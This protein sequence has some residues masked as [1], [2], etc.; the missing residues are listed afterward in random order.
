MSE[1]E[2]SSISKDWDRTR[3]ILRK[4]SLLEACE[5]IQ[6]LC[7]EVEKVRKEVEYQKKRQDLKEQTYK[8]MMVEVQN[9][10]QKYT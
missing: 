9:V 5:V 6:T 7:L 10:I 2:I 8:T 4:P 1:I 3:A